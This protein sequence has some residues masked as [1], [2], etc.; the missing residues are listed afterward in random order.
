MDL[1]AAGHDVTSS[2]TSAWQ[3]VRVHMHF[4]MRYNYSNVSAA[5]LRGIDSFFFVC[6]LGHLPPEQSIAIE[7]INSKFTMNPEIF[8]TD[9]EYA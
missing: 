9:L 4:V 6:L 2:I 8:N 1:E 5:T 3:K 7:G